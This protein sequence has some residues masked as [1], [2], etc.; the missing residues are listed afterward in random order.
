[1][2]REINPLAWRTLGPACEW[3][4]IALGALLLL[5][6]PLSFNTETWLMLALAVP[7]M[8]STIVFPV[9]LPSM[10]V[11]LE[12]VFTFYFAISYGVAETLWV[13]VGGEL[14]GALLMSRHTRK[15]VILLNP[16]LKVVCLGVGFAAF[17]PVEQLVQDMGLGSGELAMIKLLAVGVGFFLANHVVLNLVLFLRSQHFYL[18]SAVH[19]LRW[20]L[21][22]YMGVFPLAYLGH[23]I[24]SFLGLATLLVLL[25][26]VG[27]LT[28]IIRLFNR[29]WWSNRINQ[30]CITLSMVKE[31][32]EIYSQAFA[33]A[34]EMTDSPKAM[35]L[36]LVGDGTFHGVDSDGVH[37]GRIQHH[38]LDE[39]VQN[40]KA[41]TVTDRKIAQEFF[42]EWNARSL[43]LLPLIGKTKVFGVICLG[44]SNAHGYY[45]SHQGQLRFLAHQVSIILDRNH[46]YEELERAAIT[47]AL[48]GLYN[49]HYFNEKLDEEFRNAKA[50]G[51]ELALVIFDIDHFKKYNDTYG[52]IVGDEVLRQVSAILKDVC[53]AQGMFLARYGGEEFVAFGSLTAGEASVVADEVRRRVA[54]H[55]F[56]YQEH[57]VKNITIS[58]GIAHVEEHD[59]ASPS[60]LIEKADQALYWGAKEPGR[61][62][63]AVFGPE[64]D[65]RLFIDT[66]TG[67]HTMYCLRT[68]L[69]SLTENEANFPFHFLLVDIRGMRKIN[70]EYGYEVGNRVLVD[71]SFVMKSVMRTDDLICRYMDDEFLV[72]L[73]R[74][75]HHELEVVAHRIRD[76]F[77]SHLFPIVGSTVNCDVKVLTMSDPQEASQI[78]EWLHHARKTL[79][80]AI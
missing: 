59:A 32:S 1:M 48:T 67:L 63:V 70:D 50:H 39:I 28:Y 15:T 11:S 74:L 55:Q 44:K 45:R 52:H 46:V 27:F 47:N 42:T 12:L 24:Q 20:E 78:L 80:Q 18:E 56:V 38:L 69:R 23:I 64:F 76:A 58:C 68:K 53:E 66:L 13:N 2:K 72:V 7:I 35:L 21:L 41:I 30:A 71:A 40:H 75:P 73:K 60:D 31:T 49:Y 29:L 62:R 26:P 37:H 33:L 9:T 25:V 8:A 79:S 54:G 16:T 4:V 6:Y 10:L 14:L 77:A 17:V 22:V 34:Q 51:E 5:Q 61:N 3:L 57:V 65:Q 36:K 43:V 19:A